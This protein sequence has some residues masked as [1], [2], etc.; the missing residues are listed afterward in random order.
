MVGQRCCCL[1][2]IALVGVVVGAPTGSSRFDGQLGIFD[3]FPTDKLKL[4]LQT[5]ARTYTIEG[6]EP[7]AWM[8]TGPWLLPSAAS[9]P[10]DSRRTGFGGGTAATGQQ[11]HR[12]SK[13]QQHHTTRPIAGVSPGPPQ[14]RI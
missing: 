6:A 14:G 10:T 12:R 8:Y 13:L 4:V 9:L 11:N 2:L 5:P 1:L 7:A 3:S